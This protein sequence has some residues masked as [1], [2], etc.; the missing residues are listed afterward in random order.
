MRPPGG[1]FEAC[2]GAV[3]EPCRLAS[4]AL[5]RHTTAIP[6]PLM[7]RAFLAVVILMSACL[8]TPVRAQ[9]AAAPFDGDLQRLAEILGAL[10]YLRGICG[11]N[12]G[13]KWRNEMQALIDAET[14]SGDRRA[15]MVAGFN[16]GYNGF[17]QTYRTCT[18]AASVAIRR[19]I[20]EGS[21]I[22][23]DL[24]ARYAN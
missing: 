4:G 14:P 9:D 10:H 8:A 23:R 2:F 13:A 3:S 11:S 19:Y 12:E 16:R 17:Q 24:T 5:R 20:E 18:P 22:S 21:K 1:W 15:R 6:E 7:I